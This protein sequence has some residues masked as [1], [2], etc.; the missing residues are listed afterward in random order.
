MGTSDSNGYVAEGEV[1]VLGLES[2][3]A[4]LPHS[5]EH[6]GGGAQAKLPPDLKAGSASTQS[7]P[8]PSVS[9]VGSQLCRRRWEF[10]ALWRVPEAG[11]RLF[12]CQ[13]YVD[14]KG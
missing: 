4:N 2:L 11:N 7:G 6:P 9:V 3:F 8:Q 10:P 13:V 1:E 5:A 12:L 14:Q